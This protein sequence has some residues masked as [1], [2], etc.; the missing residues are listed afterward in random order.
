MKEQKTKEKFVRSSN[1]F[2]KHKVDQYF[3]QDNNYKITFEGNVR[4]EGY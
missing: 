1:L 2:F 4:F 3:S